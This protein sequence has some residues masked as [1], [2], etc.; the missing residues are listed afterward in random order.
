MYNVVYAIEYG[1]SAS[2]DYVCDAE[3]QVSPQMNQKGCS[4]FGMNLNSGEDL[5]W[6]EKC[7]TFSCVQDE[8]MV[9]SLE[10]H[11]WYEG[12]GCCEYNNYLLNDG[13][14]TFT[15]DTG[16]EILCSKGEIFEYT[17][18][19]KILIR[20][21]GQLNYVFPYVNGTEPIFPGGGSG[22]GSWPTGS[23][24]GSW[25]TGSGWGSNSGSEGETP[26]YGSGNSS[27][28]VPAPGSK[29][30]MKFVPT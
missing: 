8:N 12:T 18:M 15:E 6:P 26:G 24:W 28:I 14:Y 27:G 5:A 7:A 4:I 17:I 2:L 25:P 3:F 10:Y 23:G 29:S 21:L 20:C 1:A 16:L 11:S 19:K 22:W 30:P 9:P 13:E